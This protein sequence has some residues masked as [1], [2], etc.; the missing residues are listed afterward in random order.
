MR[1][2]LSLLV[3]VAMGCGP[4]VI[5]ESTIDVGDSWSYD[6]ALDYTFEV[7]DTSQIY[8]LEFIV[9][10]SA[11]YSFQNLYVNVKTTYPDGH[12][13]TDAVSLAVT[14]KRGQFYG[15]CSGDK[16]ALPIQLHSSFKFQ[17][18]GQHQISIVQHSRKPDLSDVYGGTLRLVEATKK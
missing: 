3:L 15:Q 17:Q 6:E 14:D 4:V 8:E 18:I 11:D 5:Y 1:V 9:E 13:A 10:H 16:C 12:T 2:L 7:T